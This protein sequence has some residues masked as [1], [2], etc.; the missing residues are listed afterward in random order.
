MDDTDFDFLCEV[1]S[2]DEAKRL[3]TILVEWCDGD[4]NGFPVQLALLTR[5][6]WYVAASI[7]RSVNESRKLLEAHFAENR[8]QAKVMINDFARTIDDKNS[9]LKGIVETQAKAT[10][11]TVSTLRIRLMEV[12]E[13]ART[14]RRSLEKAMSEFDQARA[15]LDGQ[16]QKLEKVCKEM[17]QRLEW[18]WFLWYA[19]GG[20]VIFALGM[21]Y[22]HFTLRH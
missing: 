3:R 16:R 18:R 11:Q 20:L 14:I 17:D 7:P 8:R 22:E 2:A 5:A 15:S 12:D 4:E 6:Q 9:D 21:A 19:L 1:V 13:F 10:E